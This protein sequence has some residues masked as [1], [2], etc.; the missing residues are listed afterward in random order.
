MSKDYM[1]KMIDRAFKDPIAN[2]LLK[3][4]NLTELQHETLVIDV[5]TDILS[6]NKISYEEKTIFRDNKVSRGSFSRTLSQARK[7]IVSSIFTII[8][9]N[10]IGI[11]G[12][13][14]L[15][16]YQILAEKLQEYKEIIESSKPET[17]K[18]LLK[19]I[20][21]EL[22]E[23]IKDLSKPTRIKSV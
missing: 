20:E 13:T 5:L 19:R 12:A 23:G 2:I 9:M 8:L 21:E 16:E 3:Y 14:T 11:L 17:S 10:Y 4:S 1:K 18:L 7:N 15:E 6:D 22:I